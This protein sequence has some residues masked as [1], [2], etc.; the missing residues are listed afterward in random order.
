MY[1]VLCLCLR[2]SDKLEEAANSIQRF[3]NS[4]ALTNDFYATSVYQ[5][6]T[7]LVSRK[8]PAI[9]VPIMLTF[10]EDRDDHRSYIHESRSG[11]NFFRP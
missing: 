1:V 9:S 7:I 6:T 11:L 3:Y 4:Y 2:A 8:C 5:V 10:N